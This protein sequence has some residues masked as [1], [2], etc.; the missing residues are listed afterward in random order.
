[1][2][3][4]VNVIDGELTDIGEPNVGVVQFDFDDANVDGMV[5][6]LT[7]LIRS[8][9]NGHCVGIEEIPE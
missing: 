9:K 7:I 2:K 6:F 4:R 3:I 5:D 8:L 1:M